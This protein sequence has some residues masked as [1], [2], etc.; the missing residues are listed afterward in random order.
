MQGT[1]A[2]QYLALE[3]ERERTSIYSN[4]GQ[5]ACIKPLPPARRR[6]GI[7]CSSPVILTGPRARVAITPMWQMEKLGRRELAWLTQYLSADK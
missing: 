1:L 2:F 4:P 5:L 7:I 3:A 6:A